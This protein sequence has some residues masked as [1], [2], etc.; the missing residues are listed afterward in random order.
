MQHG[1]VNGGQANTLE[2]QSPVFHNSEIQTADYRPGRDGPI[3]RP[4]FKDCRYRPGLHDNPFRGRIVWG[5][6]NSLPKMRALIEKLKGMLA[7]LNGQQNQANREDCP[8]IQTLPHVNHPLTKPV[9]PTHKGVGEENYYSAPDGTKWPE[10]H[11]ILGHTYVDQWGI[12]YRQSEMGLIRS[13]AYF[14]GDIARDRYTKALNLDSPPPN[15]MKH[16]GGPVSWA[17]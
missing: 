8:K 6:V 7:K 3:I 2:A 17:I 11:P 16:T 14:P 15:V 10:G 13:A 9:E 5:G 12:G 4:V 1:A